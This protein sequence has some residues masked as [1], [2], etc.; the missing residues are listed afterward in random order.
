[1][2][3]L[4]QGFT[5]SIS[6]WQQ[7]IEK[8]LKGKNY[9]QA[10]LWEIANGIQLDPVAHQETIDKNKAKIEAIQAAQVNKTNT[11]WQISQQFTAEE[12]SNKLL[13]EMLEDGVDALEVKAVSPELLKKIL[14]SYVHFALENIAD[15]SALKKH[16]LAN[17]D[18]WKNCNISVTSDPIISSIYSGKTFQFNEANYTEP[19]TLG[20]EV[21]SFSPTTLRGD[22]LASAG[23]NAISEIALTLLAGS[24]W[25]KATEGKIPAEQTPTIAL[26][27]S[28]NFYAEVAKFRAMRFLWQ[29]VLQ[30]HK[31]PTTFSLEGRETGLTFSM[32]DRHNNMLR[33][34]TGTFSAVIGGVDRIVN[35]PFS[36]GD[37]DAPN[38]KLRMAKNINLL[39]KEESFLDKVTD[40]ASGS[41]YLENATL[42]FVEKAWDL[43]LELEEKHGTFTQAAKAGAVQEI[44][45]TDK[46]KLEGNIASGSKII[47]GVNKFPNGMEKASDEKYTPCF[48]E[49]IASEIETVEPFTID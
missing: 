29:K 12:H 15:I 6:D 28:T 7:A 46:T 40:P 48:P 31:L 19:C 10:M 13:L 3:K 22:Y 11:S 21:N 45:K 26:G 18:E 43:F 8:E 1:M 37:T 23:A 14:P 16:C 42:Q 36:T 41:Y 20:S 33:S 47:I 2:E 17:N 38:F 32:K 25:L 34:T 39:C 9:E 44:L 4:F 49:K 30:H 24:E 5:P 35:Q 27:F